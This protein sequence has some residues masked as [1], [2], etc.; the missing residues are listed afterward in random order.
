MVLL[1]LYLFRFSVGFEIGTIA[2]IVL[3][4]ENK[5]AVERG[6]GKCS[7]EKKGNK[8]FE[9]AHDG[10]VISNIA[11]KAGFFLIKRCQ[12]FFGTISSTVSG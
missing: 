11:K 7:E 9:A 2:A 6:A 10:F 12:P 5:A 1:M 3:S 4:M 8:S